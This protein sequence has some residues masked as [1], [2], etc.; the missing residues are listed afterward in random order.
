[1]NPRDRRVVVCESILCPTQF[2]QTLAK[3]LFKRYEVRINRYE[4]HSYV[5]FSLRIEGEK[6]FVSL[7]MF[8]PGLYYLNIFVN[9]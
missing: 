6:F 8:S 7:L 2:R 4:I 1:M 9:G 3:V 5:Y